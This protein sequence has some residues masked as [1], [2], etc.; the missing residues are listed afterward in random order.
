M[1]NVTLGP[2]FLS[3]SVQTCAIMAELWI[4]SDTSSASKSC[5]GTLFSMSVSNFCSY[6]VRRTQY[7]RPF[8][9]TA[10]RFFL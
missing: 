3:N 8:L 4:L 2:C 7:D 1:A 10:I 6:T 9:A 5:Q